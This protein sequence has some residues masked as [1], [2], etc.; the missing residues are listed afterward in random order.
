MVYGFPLD[1]NRLSPLR[2][3]DKNHNS[4]LQFRE[5]V[6]VYLQDEIKHGAIMGLFEDIPIE[7]CHFSPFMT[8]EKSDSDKRRKND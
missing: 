8:K 1:F 6:D 3:E 2:W 5:Q 7:S 4:A